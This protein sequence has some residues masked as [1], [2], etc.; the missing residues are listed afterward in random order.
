MK[1]LGDPKEVYFTEDLSVVP[2]WI[3]RNCVHNDSHRGGACLTVSR[4]EIV[5]LLLL[6][7][8]AEDRESLPYPEYT[9]Y[10]HLLCEGDIYVFDPD[11]R[12]YRAKVIG[13]VTE[14]Y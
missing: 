7:T 4:A 3:D 1:D 12:W 6:G 10:D 13:T 11:L 5:M 14:V 9:E 2:Y 8:P